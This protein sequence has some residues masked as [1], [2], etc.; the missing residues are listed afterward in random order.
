M[1]VIVF[2]EEQTRT[3]VSCVDGQNRAMVLTELCS[4]L[5]LYAPAQPRNGNGG[6]GEWLCLTHAM[7]VCRTL[8]E[9][10]KKFVIS[11]DGGIRLLRYATP[12]TD[13][14]TAHVFG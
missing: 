7:M 6:R 1:Q 4:R 2:L 13:A 3:I 12:T 14:G 9:H 5:Y 10:I 8:T 11:L